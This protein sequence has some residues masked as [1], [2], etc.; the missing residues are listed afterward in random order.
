MAH[1]IYDTIYM[2]GSS[3]PRDTVLVCVI[4]PAIARHVA[5][6]PLVRYMLIY[7]ILLLFYFCSCNDKT[8]WLDDGPDPI[9]STS[10][11]RTSCEDLA[12]VVTSTLLYTIST[13][14]HP[15]NSSGLLHDCLWTTIAPQ[16]Y[17]DV[18][19]KYVNKP[20]TDLHLALIVNNPVRFRTFP[21]HTY[22]RRMS[23]RDICFS[24]LAYYRITMFAKATILVRICLPN[25][26]DVRKPS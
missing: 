21:A 8:M 13:T 3:V 4:K 25:N 16:A 5:R 6:P 26:V 11:L 9:H 18:V 17:Q 10:L 14:A 19:C 23:T 12:D 15:A 20:D 7:M 1:A 2:I 22:C 24:G